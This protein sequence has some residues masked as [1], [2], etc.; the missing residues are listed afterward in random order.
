MIMK[1]RYIQPLLAL[2]ISSSILL[3]G[4]GEEETSESLPSDVVAL[5]NEASSIGNLNEDTYYVLTASNYQC[6]PIYF[7]E[8]TFEKGT[9]PDGVNPSRVMWFKD[10]F[11]K[12][13]TLYGSKND[14][15]IFRTTGVLDEKIEFERFKDYGYTVGL[16]GLEDLHSGRYK[17]STDVKDYCTYPG[18]DTDEIIKYTNDEIILDCINQIEI[19]KDEENKDNPD[20]YITESGTLI[21]QLFTKD[22]YYPFYLYEGTVEHECIFKADVRAMGAFE[23]VTSY[24]YNFTHDGIIEINIPSWFNSG[25]YNVNGQGIFRYVK[26]I[27]P[28]IDSSEYYNTPNID[29]KKD[30]E[31]KMEDPVVTE[32]QDTQK[33]QQVMDTKLTDEEIKEMSKFNVTSPGEI[34]VNVSFS[35]YGE[36]DPVDTSS[37]IVAIIMTPEGGKLSMIPDGNGGL[38][39]TFNAG[40]GSYYIKYFNLGGK[41]PSIRVN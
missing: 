35:S 25:Y 10:D 12:I 24:D 31:L 37:E 21:S 38:T 41:T 16:C 7:G 33:L 23:H 26:D 28:N 36:S 8:A 5:T 18:G 11:D 22:K 32:A 17:I 9:T 6:T 27:N 15:L 4:C 40:A 20:T 34:T 39:K 30:K 2:I 1:K 13:P 14:K 29:P 19:R 3:G